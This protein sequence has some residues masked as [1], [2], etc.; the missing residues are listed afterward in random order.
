MK[1]NM[2]QTT[3]TKS[4][5]N[6]PKPDSTAVATEKPPKEPVKLK[7]LPRKN[8]F[9]IV[10]CVIFFI[11]FLSVNSSMNNMK[12]GLTIQ[13]RNLTSDISDL[14]GAIDEA[15]SKKEEQEKINAITMSDEEAKIALDEAT[16]QGELVAKLQNTY[17]NIN[18]S[19]NTDDYNNNVNSLDACFDDNS[20]DARV[21]WYGYDE[22][23]PGTWEFSN[24]VSFNGNMARILWM[25]FSDKD[26]TLLAYCTASYNVDTKLFSSVE[27]KL[28]KYA[29]ANVGTDDSSEKGSEIKSVI[30]SLKQLSKKG[31]IDA[32]NGKLDKNT[33]DT[34]SQLSEAREAL[35]NSDKA[36]Q[37][38]YDTRY[39]TGLDSSKKNAEGGDPNETNE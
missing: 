28:T 24:K 11:A 36:N 5:S 10:L 14:Q 30:D 7:E 22:Y 1:V 16:R 3:D 18:S 12:M 8:K 19:N 21:R 2:N 31:I 35:K 17:K 6:Q 27:Y 38:G 23:I 26:H 29:E 20:K 33:V 25:C 39:D 9:W 37:T 13:L 15:K 4:V 32:D 34:N